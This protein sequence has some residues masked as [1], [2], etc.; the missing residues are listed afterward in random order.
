MPV[1]GPSLAQRGPNPNWETPHL[2]KGPKKKGGGALSPK[3]TPLS[4]SCRRNTRWQFFFKQTNHLLAKCQKVFVFDSFVWNLIVSGLWSREGVDKVKC[5][6]RKFAS[7]H[8][9]MN[10]LPYMAMTPLS[11]FDLLL[12]L[13][14]SG[15]LAAASSM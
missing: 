15:P 13:N 3:G 8:P 5:A 1:P 2:K 14:L 10:S 9:R 11:Y 4:Q 12:L 6:I 7:V